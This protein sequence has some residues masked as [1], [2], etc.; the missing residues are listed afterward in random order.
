MK[1]KTMDQRATRAQALGV[2]HILV[3][4]HE[5]C[6]AV[7]AALTMPYT[8]SMLTNCWISQIRAVRDANPDELAVI[9]GNEKVSALVGLNVKRQVCSDFRHC[10]IATHKCTLYWPYP[11][12]SNILLIPVVIYPSSNLSYLSS[13]AWTLYYGIERLLLIHTKYE[14]KHDLFYK[15]E[16]SIVHSASQQEVENAA[17]FFPS[18]THSSVNILEMSYKTSPGLSYLNRSASTKPRP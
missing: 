17:L 11:H 18:R 4:G 6:G 2:K 12:V 5:N 16:C 10:S 7:K 3:C 1:R 14:Q 13:T 15:I 9:E 8:N